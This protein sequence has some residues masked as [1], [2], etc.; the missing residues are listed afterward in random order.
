MVDV[1]LSTFKI[2]Q[3][4]FNK[5]PPILLK[6]CKKAAVFNLIDFIFIVLKQLN[7]KRISKEEPAWTLINLT[8]KCF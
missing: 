8:L 6:V 4:C 7:S 5:L 1:T 3:T 2:F